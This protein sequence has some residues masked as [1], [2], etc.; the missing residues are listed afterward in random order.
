VT[1]VGFNS[2]SPILDID[3]AAK[4]ATLTFHFE[5]PD[6]S[7]FGGNAEVLANGDMEF[8]ECDSTNLIHPAAD[9]YEV[10]QSSVMVN[11][12]C[13]SEATRYFSYFPRPC[14]KSEKPS[15]ESVLLLNNRVSDG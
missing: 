6:Y 11:L 9:I 4:T 8:D 3:E 2:T 7:G 14:T 12:P 5:T 13:G 10:T 15:V 1:E